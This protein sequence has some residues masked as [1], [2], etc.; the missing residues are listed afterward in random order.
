MKR[1]SE[2]EL[3]LQFLQRKYRN[4]NLDELLK[5]QKQFASAYRKLRMAG[6]GSAV[7]CRLLKRYAKE[8][9]EWIGTG[10]RR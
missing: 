1:R 4:K 6:F 8:A 2:S 9:A 5:D 7:P 10:T 3:A